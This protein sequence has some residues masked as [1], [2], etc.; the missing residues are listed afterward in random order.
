M[1]LVGVLFRGHSQVNGAVCQEK[2][3][4]ST[5]I[6]KMV[7]PSILQGKILHGPVFFYVVILE[8][9]HLT[10]QVKNLNIETE[11]SEQTVLAQISLSQY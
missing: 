8:T 4:N 10:A 9:K 3:K 6:I 1:Q 2:K 5:C 11:K 7:T